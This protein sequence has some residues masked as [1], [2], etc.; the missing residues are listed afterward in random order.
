MRDWK[1]LARRVVLSYLPWL[2]V[3]VEKIEL[4]DGRIIDE[5]LQLRGRDFVVVVAFTANGEVVTE[6]SYKHGPRKVSLALPAGLIE[7]AEEPAVAARRELLEETGYEAT[8]WQSLG[9]FIVDSNYGLN[10]E[11]MYVARDARQVREP[12]SGDLEEIAIE[13]H[14]T[15]EIIAALRSGEVAQLSSAAALGVALTLQATFTS[16]GK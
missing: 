5:Y 2:E 14:T 8:R 10:T 12:N 13:L 15:D 1:T 6:R 16:G 3:S 7:A 9:S 11:H 4:P